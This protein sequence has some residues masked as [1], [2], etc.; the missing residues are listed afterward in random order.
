[1]YNAKMICMTCKK[2]EQERSD[3]KKVC[4]L[5]RQAVLSGNLNYI[6]DENI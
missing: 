3:Y 5:E 2:A 4:E 1:M 6:Y